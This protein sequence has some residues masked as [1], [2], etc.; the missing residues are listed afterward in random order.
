VRAKRTRNKQEIAD[1]VHELVETR[2]AAGEL[3][4]SDLTVSELKIIQDVFVTSLQ[5]VFHPRI[6]YPTT[7]RSTQEMAAL[8]A[9]TP[10]LPAPGSSTSNVSTGEAQP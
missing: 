3:D 6:A 9:P 4:E 5:G 8:P 10:A 1:V 2:L 7:P